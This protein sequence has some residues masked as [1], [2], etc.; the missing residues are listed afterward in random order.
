MW[1]PQ[2]E[3][4]P[5][6][7]LFFVRYYKIKIPADAGEQRWSQRLG[8]IVQ[9]EALVVLVLSGRLRGRNGKSGSSMPTRL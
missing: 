5:L 6:F 9:R 1:M 7:C 3:R 8:R 2:I 4:I